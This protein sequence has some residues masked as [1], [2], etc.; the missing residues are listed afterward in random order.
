MRRVLSV[1][2]AFVL[3]LSMTMMANYTVFA[4]QS[5]DFY[6]SIS[7][8]EATITFYTGTG[9]TVDIPDTLVGYPLTCIGYEAFGNCSGLT[10]VTIPSSVTSIEDYA[11][12]DCTGLTQINVDNNN[13]QYSSQAGVLF[14]KAKTSLIQYPAGKAGSYIIPSSVTSI[15]YDAF[16]GCTGLTSVTIPNSVTFVSS[17][18]FYGCTGLTS[19]AIP[20]S[21]TYIHGDAFYGCTGLTSV[22]IPNSVTEI[23]GGAFANCNG[24]TVTYFLGNAPTMGSRVFDS[25][26][27]TFKVYYISGSTGFA[28]LW[29]GYETVIFDPLA[30]PKLAPTATPT[31]TLVPT[32]TPTPTPTATPTQVPVSSVKMSKISASLKVTQTLQL[33]ATVSPS[34]AAS[35]AVEWTSSNTKIAEVSLTGEV[36]AKGPGSTTITATAVSG[37]K[38]ATCKVTVTQSVTSVKLSKTSLTLSKGKTFKLTAT[39]NP[40]NASNKKVTWKSSNTKIATVSSTG[41]IKGIIKGTVYIYVCTLDGN[42]SAKCKVTIK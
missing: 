42:K 12:I 23:E 26:A 1:S 35:T 40:S 3:V 7:N 17:E 15:V 31:P 22:T 33:T 25:C 41:T 28:N 30:T 2:L 6:Y 39:V 13:E 36:T 4:E 21:V 9:G 24:L 16:L 19:V 8:S 10:R 32:A 5:G 11:F 27:P 18:A 20:D 14:D 34:N 38:I 29:Y 37:G